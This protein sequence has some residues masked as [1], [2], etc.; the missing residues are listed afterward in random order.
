MGDI[1]CERVMFFDLK[2][3]F[4]IKMVCFEIMLFIDFF[5]LKYMNILYF[6]VIFRY[7]F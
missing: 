7:C 6:L 3:Y 5:F 1:M 4:N 2:I